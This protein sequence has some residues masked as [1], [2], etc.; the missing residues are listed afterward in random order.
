MLNALGLKLPRQLLHRARTD[1]QTSW[2][3]YGLPSS[4][5]KSH[6]SSHKLQGEGVSKHQPLNG[7]QGWTRI[8]LQEEGKGTNVHKPVICPE[9]LLGTFWQD[10]NLRKYQTN[11]KA[12]VAW[13][14]W[15]NC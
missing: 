1:R 10:Q 9:F 3:D 8:T 5:F 12:E 14:E 2:A 15:P 7:L 13:S 11:E 6:H 4:R